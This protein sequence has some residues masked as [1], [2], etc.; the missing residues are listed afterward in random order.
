MTPAAQAVGNDDLGQPKTYSFL[1]FLELLATVAAMK[2]HYQDPVQIRR[3]R[4][5]AGLTQKA[6]A[7]RVGVSK[8]HISMV[9]RGTAGASA[10]LLARLA[11]AFGC[12]VA[13]LMP[14]PV[15]ST[16]TS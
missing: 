10:P 13:D 11:A 12:E 14:S 3:R 2:A 6:L 4:I 16:A 1:Y 15:P 5:E 8:A 7:K 9:E